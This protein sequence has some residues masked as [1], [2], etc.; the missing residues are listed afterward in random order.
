M[1]ERANNQVSLLINSSKVEVTV[2]LGP[3]Y[4]RA[5][6]V[7]GF[8]EIKDALDTV[9]AKLSEYDADL[10]LVVN[11]SSFLV[12]KEN[13]ESMAEVLEELLQHLNS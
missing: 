13:A 4:L 8:S 10:N 3:I 6:E 5:E 12:P 11:W 7:I 1:T 9:K 2:F